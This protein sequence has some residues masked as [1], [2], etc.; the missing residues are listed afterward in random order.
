MNNLKLKLHTISKRCFAR[1][2]KEANSMRKPAVVSR[3][4]QSFHEIS[5]RFNLRYPVVS[6]ENQSFHEVSTRFMRYSIVSRGIQAFHEIFT[7]CIQW[8]TTDELVSFARLYTSLVCIVVTQYT[9]KSSVNYNGYEWL[10]RRT[11]KKI[12]LVQLG[13]KDPDPFKY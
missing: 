10:R 9:T 1:R 12:S 4:I 7:Q 6:R 11:K 5:S 8:E 13:S 2:H 3:D